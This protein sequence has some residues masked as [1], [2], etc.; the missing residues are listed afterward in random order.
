MIAVL[1]KHWQPQR[2][3]HLTSSHRWENN[4]NKK[5]TISGIFQ[6]VPDQHGDSI[7]ASYVNKRMLLV[8]AVLTWILT[9]HSAHADGFAQLKARA[10]AG[11]V[12][13]QITLADYY[14]NYGEPAYRELAAQ[15]YLKAAKQSNVNAQVALFFHHRYGVCGSDNDRASAL[16][17]E[18]QAAEN[19]NP[20]AQAALAHNYRYGLG[21]K[22]KNPEESLRWSRKAAAQGES[23]SQY[24]LGVRYRDGSDV[25]QDDKMALYWLLK[26]ARNT[27]TPEN[28]LQAAQIYVGIAYKKG[29]GTAKNYRSAAYW[30]IQATNMDARGDADALL[31]DARYHL[32]DLYRQGSDVKRNPDEAIRLFRKAAENN[33]AEAQ[34]QLG[35]AYAFGEGVEQNDIEAKK[36]FRRAADAG[37]SQALANLNDMEK[38]DRNTIPV[39]TER[40]TRKTPAYEAGEAIGSILK[41]MKWQSELQDS[42]GNSGGAAISSEPGVNPELARCHSAADSRIVECYTWQGECDVIGCQVEVSCRGSGPFG[43]CARRNYGPYG[44][45]GTFYCDPNNNDNVDFNRNNVIHDAC[46]GKFGP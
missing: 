39:Q 38:S 17:W 16:Y 9:L 11:D 10:Q 13:A 26:A 33:H 3:I 27:S 23:M 44:E 41:F 30:L 7:R 40:T 19:G 36:W 22:P 35:M 14:C 12:T 31:N 4:V 15:W 8:L 5:R 1:L 21:G 20:K 24:S 45:S 42:S 43:R 2:I 29:L 34:N 18:Q 46:N 37:S 28:V 6:P 32:A 25:P